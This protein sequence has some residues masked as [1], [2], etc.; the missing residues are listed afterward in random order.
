MK[1]FI[2]ILVF[3]LLL[4]PLKGIC[5]EFIWSNGYHKQLSKVDSKGIIYDKPYGDKV[6]H[7]KNG[8]I[9]NSPYGGLP[10]GRIAE[11]GKIWNKEVGGKPIG[12]YENGR[13]YN[14]IIGG[15]VI[16][17]TKDIRGCGWFLLN[18]KLQ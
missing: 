5:D 16:G 10:V 15:A 18:K 17:I 9:Y 6:A 11:D 7:V 4:C 13:V 14:S 8:V 2:I 12:R 1:K 3:I